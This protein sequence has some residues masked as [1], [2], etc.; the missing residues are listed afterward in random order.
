LKCRT[1][2]SFQCQSFAWL[3]LPEVVDPEVA[4]ERSL[5]T[6]AGTRFSQPRHRLR[7]SCSTSATLLTG[8][9]VNHIAAVA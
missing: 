3:S 2:T 7:S 6:A 5:V 1:G 9:E 4:G 8:S